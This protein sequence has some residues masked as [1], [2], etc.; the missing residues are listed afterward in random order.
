M[1]AA[2]TSR[3]AIPSFTGAPGPWLPPQATAPALSADAGPRPGRHWYVTGSHSLSCASSREQ[4]SPVAV[5]L[6]AGYQGDLVFQGVG[7]AADQAGA[8][9]PQQRGDPHVF[10]RDQ[11]GET[12][13]ALLEGST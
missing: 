5:L 3:Q 7:L 1:W 4:R 13:D 8:H 6:F 9:V 10:G 12:A 2:S 11:S